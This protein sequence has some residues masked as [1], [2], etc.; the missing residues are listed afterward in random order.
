MFGGFI[1]G[2]VT[3]AENKRASANRFAQKLPKFEEVDGESRA[4]RLQRWK[5]FKAAQEVRASTA[6]S[7]LHRPAGASH[8][9]DRATESA[10]AVATGAVCT[11]DGPTKLKFG[12]IVGEFT[13][14]MRH[15]TGT[16]HTLTRT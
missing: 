1:T 3:D 5:R 14:I 13:R 6:R 4:D 15:T 2:G 10:P 8:R 7:G 11:I 12:T 9:P 16:S